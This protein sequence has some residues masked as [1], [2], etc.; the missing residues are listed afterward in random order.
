MN[1]IPVPPDSEGEQIQLDLYGIRTKFTPTPSDPV[2]DTWTEVWDRV[3][4]TLKSIVTDSF[5]V[6]G[7][8]LS[9]TRT[10]VRGIGSIPKAIAE[11]I[12]ASHKVASRHEADAERSVGRVTFDKSRASGDVNDI[13]SRLNQRG[14]PAKLIDTSD[15]NVVLLVG[16]SL[17]E[18]GSD[19]MIVDLLEQ[20]RRLLSNDGG[21]TGKD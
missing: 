11:R 10:F 17:T 16:R 7:D 4:S 20:S 14:V 13:L 8:T 18:Q 19:Q 1:T 5:G 6:V 21:S 3:H 9:S 15:G 12:T 2:P